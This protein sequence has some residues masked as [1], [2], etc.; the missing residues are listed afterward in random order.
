M[1]EVETVKDNVTNLH[2]QNLISPVVSLPPPTQQATFLGAVLVFVFIFFGLV[3][4]I[5]LITAILS[6][7]KLRSNII[8]IFIVSVSN[9]FD[10]IRLTTS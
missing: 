9:R 6:V 8:N 10:T 3:G 5:L 1:N 2:F 7:K 4:N